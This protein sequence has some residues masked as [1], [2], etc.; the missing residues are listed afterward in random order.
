MYGS[1]TVG[2]QG[3]PKI[4]KVTLIQRLVRYEVNAVMDM[5]AEH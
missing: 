5:Q 4:V 2:A 3:S 1:S